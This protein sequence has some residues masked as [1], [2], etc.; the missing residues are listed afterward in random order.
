[1]KALMFILLALLNSN[2]FASQSYSTDTCGYGDSTILYLEV[3]E[4]PKFLS[5]NYNTAL[6]YIYSNVQYPSEINVQGKVI[7]SFVVTKSGEIEKIKVEKKLCDECDN[8]VKKVLRYMPKWNAGKKNG[9]AVNTLLLLA[10][11][12]KLTATE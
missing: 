9:K 12:F 3:D 11:N 2:I 8:E 6:E 10:V 4:L 7:V 5:S 1:M